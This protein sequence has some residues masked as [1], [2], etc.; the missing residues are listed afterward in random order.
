MK[1][2]HRKSWRRGVGF[3]VAPKFKCPYLRS[4]KKRGLPY[5][6]S[7]LPGLALKAKFFGLKGQINQFGTFWRFLFCTFMY[8]LQRYSNAQCRD[9]QGLRTCR[10]LLN[11]PTH[12]RRSRNLLSISSDF[13]GGNQNKNWKFGVNWQEE[14]CSAELKMFCNHNNKISDMLHKHK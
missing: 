2:N 8:Y 12:T 3:E 1:T 11:F 10:H 4:L 9:C 5:W 13:L 6:P 14:H 7:Q